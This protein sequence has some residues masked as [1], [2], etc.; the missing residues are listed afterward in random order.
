MIEAFLTYMR[1]EL[2]SSAN[3]VEAYRRDLIQWADFVTAGGRSE[4]RPETLGLPDLRKWILS[5]ARAGAGQTTVRR[6]VQSLRAFYRYLLRMGTVASNPATDLTLPKLAKPLP[7]FVR[8]EETNAVIDSEFD[9]SDYTQLRDKLIV[10]MLYSTGMRCSELTGLLDKAV[11]S[12]AG[13][14]KVLGKRN[15]ERIIPFGAELAQMIEK[16]R[17]LRNELIAVRAPE[18]FLRPT[19]EPLYRKLVYNIVHRE[20]GGV[21]HAERLSPHVLRHSF[22]TD[23]LNNGAELTAVQQLLGHA[24]L[25]TTQ[26]YTHISYRELQQNYQQ[27]HP[28]ATKKGG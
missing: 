2:N 16:Y 19:G 8:Q 12:A 4:F 28:R 3:T 22:A 7:V 11:D 1:C 20:L 25:S 18:F 13:E 24:S 14:L 6:K 17:A 27:A 21:A 15:K 5:V 26:I 10:N 23:M 9:E